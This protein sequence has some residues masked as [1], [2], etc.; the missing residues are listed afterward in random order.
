LPELLERLEVILATHGL[1]DI[2]ITRRMTGCPNG[3]AR[4]YVSEI[5]L[6][7]KGPGRYNLHLGGGFAGE[8]LNRPWKENLDEA[9]ILATLE[10]LLARYATEREDDEHFGDF[11]IRSGIVT[12]AE[13]GAGYQRF[14]LQ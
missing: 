3:C 11:L 9:E 2:P 10:P 1:S 13:T 6:V 7:G 12:A 4:P 14:A 8:R 5:G